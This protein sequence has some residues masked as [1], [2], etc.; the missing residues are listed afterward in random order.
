MSPNNKIGLIRLVGML[1]ALPALAV[2]Y[3][4]AITWSYDIE[5]TICIAALVWVAL[6]YI[7]SKLIRVSCRK[8][9]GSMEICDG[10]DM[11]IYQCTKCGQKIDSGYHS[12]Y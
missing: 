12:E 11:I 9:G 3:W 5:L 7:F 10:D 1:T 8:C 6:L 4:I 2:S